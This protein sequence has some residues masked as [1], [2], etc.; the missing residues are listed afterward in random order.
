MTGSIVAVIGCLLV[1]GG[2]MA[3]WV[4]R[5]T[6]GFLAMVLGILIIGLT[7]GWL[8]TGIAMYPTIGC[9]DG[10]STAVYQY[11]DNAVQGTDCRLLGCG[12]VERDRALEQLGGIRRWA[13]GQPDRCVRYTYLNWIGSFE[14]QVWE[15]YRFDQRQH[16]FRGAAKTLPTPTQKGA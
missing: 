3:L 12:A 2:F 16:A 15:A 4:L 5:H 1:V 8:V 7:G 6:G 10:L 11:L 13:H 9:E 14:H